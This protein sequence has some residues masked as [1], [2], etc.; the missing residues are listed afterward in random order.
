MLRIA[1]GAVTYSEGALAAAIRERERAKEGW[2]Y[3]RSQFSNPH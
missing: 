2:E 1:E 3:A